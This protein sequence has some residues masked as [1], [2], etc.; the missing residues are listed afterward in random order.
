MDLS[1][2]KQCLHPGTGHVSVVG[3]HCLT[4]YGR[5]EGPSASRQVAHNIIVPAAKYNCPDEKFLC[6]DPGTLT[7]SGELNDCSTHGD[8]Y[9]GFCYCHIGWGGQDC[10][11]QVCKERCPDVCRRRRRLRCRAPPAPGAYAG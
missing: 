11:A 7:C 1:S 8:C 4:E 2:G 5:L 9:R 6:D 3:L 10:S